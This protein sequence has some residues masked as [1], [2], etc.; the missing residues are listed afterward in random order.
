MVLGQL[1]R[2]ASSPEGVPDFCSIPVAAVAR[3]VSAGAN[4][5]AVQPIL[6]HAS[7]AMTLDRYADLFDSD[8]DAVADHVDEAAGRARENVADFLRTVAIQAG[9]SEGLETTTGPMIRGL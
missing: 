6:G 3:A 8:L 5:K 1:T 4:V 7:A 2:D 9:Q